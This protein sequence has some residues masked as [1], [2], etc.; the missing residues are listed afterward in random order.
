[1][2]ILLAED[3]ELLGSGLQEYLKSKEQFIVDWVKDGHSA[4]L[5]LKTESFDAIIL[6]I[7]LPKIDG[8]KIVELMRERG[9]KTPVLILTA[10]D[11][12]EDR[13]K[14]LNL[15]ADDYMTKP[16]ELEEVVARLRAIQRR[17]T[18]RAATT[19]TC[20]D[21]TIKPESFE[22]T[23]KGEL[24]PLTKIEF[25][26]FK[27]LLENNG[28]VVQREHLNQILYGWN[29]Y[30]D[31]NAIEVHIHNLRKKFGNK[32]IKTIRGIGYMFVQPT[33]KEGDK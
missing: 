3:D 32:T 30:I 5:A 33:E 7:G 26:L 2:R 29:K 1:M 25:S 10:K 6:D 22:V 19:I 17:S 4:N 8:Y 24:I 14:G 21:I 27:K 18:G 31:S 20:G 28:K 9:D 13:I 23:L 16:F 15:G 11:L 12:L